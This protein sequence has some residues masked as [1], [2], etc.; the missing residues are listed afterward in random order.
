LILS[1]LRLNS[2]RSIRGSVAGM[3]KA[4]AKRNRRSS[5]PDSRAHLD[6]ID[7]QLLNALQDVSEQNGASLSAR[8]SLSSSALLRRVRRLRAAGYILG[9][10]SVVNRAMLSPRLTAFVLIQLSAVAKV[11]DFCLKLAELDEVQY[12]GG[13]SG[14]YDAIAIVTVHDMNEFNAFADAHLASGTLVQRC[15]SV[16][17]RKVAKDTRKL[18]LDERDMR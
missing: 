16:F 7:I 2:T 11:P 12:A 17:A 4:S 10:T 3:R 1:N 5:K 8:V 18:V 15:Q 6:A 14:D 13:I 9:E